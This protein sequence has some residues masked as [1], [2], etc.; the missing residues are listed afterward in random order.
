MKGIKGTKSKALVQ[1]ICPTCGDYDSTENTWMMLPGSDIFIR[2]PFHAAHTILEKGTRF[3]VHAYIYY[4][5]SSF[6][7][8]LSQFNILIV[9]CLSLLFEL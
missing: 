3:P 8:Y 5:F 1:E 9:G 6:I 4:Q 7:I 2:V